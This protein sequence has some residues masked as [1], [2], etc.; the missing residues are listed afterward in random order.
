ML[1]WNDAVS[2]E[3]LRVYDRGAE[4]KSK[5]GIYDLLVSYRSGDMWAP[6]I[7]QSEALK[8]VAD[9]FIQCINNDEKPIN[10]GHSGLRV[11]RMLEACDESLKK[12]GGMIYL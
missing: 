12:Q 2:D 3:K 11:V 5:D 9:Y 1:V 8:L 4:R 7:E 6:K 10:D